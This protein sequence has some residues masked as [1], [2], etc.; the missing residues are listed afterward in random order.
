MTPFPSICAEDVTGALVQC[1]IAPGDV[2]FVHVDDAVAGQL[3]PMP[4]AERFDLLIDAVLDVIGS[5]GTLVM[6]TFTYSFARGEV[7]DSM[8]SPSALG[9]VSEHFRRR[10]T[11]KRSAH[12]LFSVAT[13]GRHA[14]TFSHPD[15][16]DCFGPESAFGTLHR[17]DGKIVAIGGELD[18]LTFI[19][20]IE[21]SATVDYR[22]FRSFQGVVAAYDGTLRPAQVRCYVRDPKQPGR[23]G[24]CTRL[25]TQVE[26]QGLLRT[27]TLG[28]L[29]MRAVNAADLFTAG[30]TMFT[31]SP[32]E[33]P[34]SS[35]DTADAA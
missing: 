27:A 19:Q 8:R 10:P 24:D 13:C 25:V 17:L 21:Q 35:D 5:R 20:Y 33:R 28:R 12:P 15:V 6:P 29:E 7:F 16:D 23:E 22:G 4:A 14:E 9:A 3:P 11:V 1:G 31:E 2:A 32:P 34:V 30:M 18:R 26:R